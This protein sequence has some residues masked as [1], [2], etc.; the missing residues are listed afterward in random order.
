MN[1]IVP[2]ILRFLIFFVL[3]NKGSYQVVYE[4]FDHPT[5]MNSGR[6]CMREQF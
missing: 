6:V 4:L 3:A 1:N 2:E 5:V